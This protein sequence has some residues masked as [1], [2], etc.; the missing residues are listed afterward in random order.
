MGIHMAIN[1]NV[2][3]LLIMGDYDL[4]IRQAQGE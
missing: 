4:L 3:E 1:M 2:Q